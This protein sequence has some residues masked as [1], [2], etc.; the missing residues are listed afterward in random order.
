MSQGQLQTTALQR[1]VIQSHSESATQASPTQKGMCSVIKGHKNRQDIDADIE[2]F[3]LVETYSSFEIVSHEVK[4]KLKWNE[5]KDRNYKHR[6]ETAKEK[7]NENV[8]A[9]SRAV[10][11]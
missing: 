4:E 3:D 1:M 10:M 7:L 11:A 6:D 5:W 2:S 9:E 8:R